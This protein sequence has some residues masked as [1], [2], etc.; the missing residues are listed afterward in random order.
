MRR[1]VEVHVLP[2]IYS[3]G[4]SDGPAPTKQLLLALVDILITTTLLN[5]NSPAGLYPTDYLSHNI[6][7]TQQENGTEFVQF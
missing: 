4:R 5:N 3:G 2:D 7:G 1:V 6:E